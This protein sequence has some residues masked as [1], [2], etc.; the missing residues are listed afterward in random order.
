V[1]GVFEKYNVVSALGVWLISIDVFKGVATLVLF[2]VCDIF[3]IITLIPNSAYLQISKEGFRIRSLFIDRFTGWE[4]VDQ[5][6]GESNTIVKYN[7]NQKHHL[8]NFDEK[9]SKLVLAKKSGSRFTRESQVRFVAPEE[10]IRKWLK[11]SLGT[12]QVTPKIDGSIEKYSI[13]PTNGVQFAE[14]IYDVQTN[15]VYIRV[16]WN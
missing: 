6:R 10:D 11:S 9:M 1:N 15:E 13:K 5:F 7:F 12:S 16:Y 8:N 4:E 2:I 14:V 3:L